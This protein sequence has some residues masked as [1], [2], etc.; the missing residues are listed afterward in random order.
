M[1]RGDVVI[2]N[3]RYTAG[4]VAERHRT[5]AGRVRIIHR[6]VDL[7]KFDP[8]AID[9]ARIA[10]LRADWGVAPGQPVILQAA[11][12]ASWK[13]H[14]T[15]IDATAQL[16]PRGALGQ[17]VVVMAGDAQGRD[18]YREGLMTRIREQDLE[19]HIRLTGHCADMPAAFA[20]ARLAIVASTEPEAFGRV[21]TEASAMGVP[22]IA[23]AIGA[24]PE[25]IRTSPAPQRTGWLVPPGDAA[26]LADAMA[27]AMAMP[28]AE[29]A[30][31]ARCARRHVETSFSVARMQ[32]ATLAVY[33]GLLGCR[34]EDS[35]RATTVHG[36]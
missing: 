9:P 35:F 11:R 24:P 33:D 22:V 16:A 32:A 6:G 19:S 4:L 21:V 23:T 31:L 14:Q 28:P 2:A 30:A 36:N 3:S 13:G 18:G 29:R 20:A 15:V 10:R 7:T 27:L 12:L 1:A 25:T 5:P 17:A 26:A 34:L 8:A